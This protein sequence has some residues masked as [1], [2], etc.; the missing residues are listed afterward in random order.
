MKRQ[1][2][3]RT[4]YKSYQSTQTILTS[5]DQKFK[6]FDNR[7]ISIQGKKLE[8]Q[9]NHW[10]EFAYKI[11]SIN[12]SPERKSRY[13]FLNLLSFPLC[14]FGELFSKTPIQGVKREGNQRGLLA[15]IGLP[16]STHFSKNQRNTLSREVQCY[17][18]RPVE[19]KKC[20][21]CIQYY[22]QWRLHAILTTRLHVLPE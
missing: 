10:I 22:P 14:F 2:T 3:S 12:F 15:T 6:I 4:F 13:C 19:P 21:Q 20:V 8:E 16:F 11:G 7:E 1:I 18:A 5:F 9:R 17:D